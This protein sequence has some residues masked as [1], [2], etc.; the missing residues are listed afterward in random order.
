MAADGGRLISFHISITPGEANELLE[1]LLE[2]DEFRSRVEADPRGTLAE[3]H[4]DVPAEFFGE[5]PVELPPKEDIRAVREQL[6]QSEFADEVA[7]FRRFSPMI[8][9]LIARFA[10]FRPGSPAV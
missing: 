2:D 8:L 3:Y 4:I 10:P 1:K 9:D 7:R 5:A 6:E